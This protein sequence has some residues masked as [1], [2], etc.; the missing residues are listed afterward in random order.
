MFCSSAFPL[1]CSRKT[2][3]LSGRGPVY[4]RARDLIASL[5]TRHRGE[6]IFRIGSRPPHT[7]LYSGAALEGD[8]GWTG[9]SRTEEEIDILCQGITATVEEVGGKVLSCSFD[10]YI[11]YRALRLRCYKDICLIPSTEYLSSGY[12][13]ITITP[14]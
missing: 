11:Q 12:P 1:N 10:A 2:L 9:I 5:L 8:E 13:P 7:E 4:D 6:Y 3:L 14:T